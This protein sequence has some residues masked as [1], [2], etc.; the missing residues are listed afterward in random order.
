[1]ERNIRENL[2]DLGLGREFLN[3]SPKAQFIRVK[4][5]KLDFIKV[6][7]FCSAKG[8]GKRIKR[9]ITD[10]EKIFVNHISDQ[11]LAYRI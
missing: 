9:Q 1:M 6:R 11:G 2:Q 4:I 7:H 10:R 8:P 3:L 5:N